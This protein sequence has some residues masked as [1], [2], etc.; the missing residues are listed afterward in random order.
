M[1]QQPL[2]RTF[3]SAAVL[4]VIAACS[5]GSDSPATPPT[6]TTQTPAITVSA[7]SS[8]VPITAGGATAAIGVTVGR[9]GGYAGAIDL[10]VEG[11]PT[12]L[13]ASASPASVANGSTTSSITLTA[14][15]AAAAGTASVTVRAKGTGVTDQT[16][17]FSLVVT[18]ATSNPTPSY[19]IAMSPASLSATGGG[20][21]V[22][23]KL[24]I[25]RAGGFAGAVTLAVSGAPTGVTAA[26]SAVVADT[27]TLTVTPS[28]SVAT[29]TSTLT[30]TAQSAGLTDRTASVSLSTTAAA[31]GSTGNIAWQFCDVTNLPVWFAYQDGSGAFTRVTPTNNLYKFDIASAKG[32]VAFVTTTAANTF[33]TAIF[34]GT[35]A[36][37]TELGTGQCQAGTSVIKRLTGTVAGMA[38]GESAMITFGGRTASLNAN[39]AFVLDSAADGSRDLIAAKS[40]VAL[41]G[42]GVT[43]TLNKV[44]IR[45]GINP[46]AGSAIPALDFSAGEAF[47]PVQKTLTVANGNGETSSLTVGYFTAQTASAALYVDIGTSGAAT[48]PYF[49]IPAAN[50]TATDRHFAAVSSIGSVSATAQTL[51]LATIFFKDAI[52]RTITLG[53]APSAVTITSVATTPS[54]RLRAQATAQSDYSNLITSSFA[55]L[56]SGVT[57]NVLIYQTMGHRGAAAAWDV[58]MPDLSAVAGWDSN[59]ALKSGASTTVSTVTTGYSSTGSL[60]PTSDGGFVKNGVQVTTIIP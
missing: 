46:A 13:S 50:Q 11:L 44:I 20:A 31:S 5:S 9:S 16:A 52:D 1:S 24:T 8:S 36:E 29:A 39:G 2:A 58:S 34:Y 35:P 3:L 55:Q 28:A 23:S 6:G 22:K 26:M 32:A 56:S 49:G 33:Q 57:R 38:G 42:T 4:A 37:L 14:T 21:A 45:R 60:S 48:R 19:T 41:N 17:V 27:A 51:R 40:I 25:T 43:T 59:W 7:A 47:A 53:A 30:V 18:A 15:A 12:G 54:P 10:S